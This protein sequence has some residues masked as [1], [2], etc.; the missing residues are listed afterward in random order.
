[1]LPTG[2]A[3]LNLVS[4]YSGSFRPQVRRRPW[5]Q[6]KQAWPCLPVCWA[7][8]ARAPRTEQQGRARG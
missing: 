3:V 2:T 4:G 5:R 8:S 7:R 6:L 1:M